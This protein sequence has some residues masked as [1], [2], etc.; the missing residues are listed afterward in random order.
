MQRSSIG[1]QFNLQDY[2]HDDIKITNFSPASA[3]S[4][5][6]AG[7]LSCPGMTLPDLQQHNTQEQRAVDVAYRPRHLTLR[8]SLD[9]TLVQLSGQ[10]YRAMALLEH[11]P[12]LEDFGHILTCWV[13]P[14]TLQNSY[15][16]PLQAQI[17]NL[18]QEERI[19]LPIAS[20]L[21]HATKLCYKSDAH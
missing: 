6:A 13:G 20:P 11:S 9:S 5:T 4:S 7:Q 21:G 15:V 17:K 2:D 18:I 3:V 16:D 19:T 14:H 8:V 10:L 1:C 12:G